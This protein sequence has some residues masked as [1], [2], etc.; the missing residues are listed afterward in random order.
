[1]KK[2]TVVSYSAACVYEII[3]V[4]YIASFSSHF[5]QDMLLFKYVTVAALCAPA[6]LWFMLALNESS[7]YWGLYAAALFKLSSVCAEFLYIFQ[8]GFVII[9]IV[10]SSVRKS[11]KTDFSKE[12]FFFL[13][14]DTVLLFYS[15]IKGSVYYA[16]NTD[17]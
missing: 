2:K 12:V 14:A 3:K 1:M 15:F 7:F 17:C 4:F 13:A 10:F 8:R 6:L 5:T 9:E 11:G 16:N